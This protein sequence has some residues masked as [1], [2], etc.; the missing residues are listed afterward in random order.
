[1]AEKNLTEE[2][3]FVVPE[4]DAQLIDRI[5]ELNAQM[6]PIESEIKFLKEAAKARLSIG[7][8]QGNVYQ[9]VV[10]ERG[11][12]DIDRERVKEEMGEEWWADH[13]KTTTYQEIRFKKIEA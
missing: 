10:A 11:R 4:N 12:T 9:C 3:I 6:K 7:E 5:A 8:H 13:C 2:P 1:M